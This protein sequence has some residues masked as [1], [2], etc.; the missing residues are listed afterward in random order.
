MHID[1]ADVRALV[2]KED[3]P[4]NFFSINLY[5]RHIRLLKLAA[6]HQAVDVVANL[7]IKTGREA[8]SRGQVKYIFFSFQF[9]LVRQYFSTEGEIIVIPNF[10]VYRRIKH[11]RPYNN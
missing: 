6:Y 2:V 8:T 3:I 7:A 9:L 10:C 5:E 11:R 4:Q 1:R